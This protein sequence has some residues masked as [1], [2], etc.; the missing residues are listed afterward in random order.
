MDLIIFDIDGTLI[1]SHEK[2]V[3]CFIDAVTTV[4]GI[5]EIDRDLH[6]YQHVTDKGILIECVYRTLNRHP[7][8]AE[9]DAI[10]D[11]YFDNF[12]AAL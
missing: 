2:E 12:L 11:R 3:D 7:T 8:K 5:K 10:Q 9:Y 4:L 6:S 1:H